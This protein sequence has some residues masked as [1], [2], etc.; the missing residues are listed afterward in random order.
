MARPRNPETD[1][2]IRL[3]GTKMSV[4]AVAA[5]LGLSE[6]VVTNAYYKHYDEVVALQKQVDRHEKAA[7]IKA[8]M[9]A[10][11]AKKGGKKPKAV[12]EAPES[13]P[14]S[15]ENGN[16]RPEGANDAMIAVSAAGDAGAV[17][18]RARVM[19]EKSLAVPL[20]DGAA[21]LIHA[22]PDTAAAAEPAEALIPELEV[23]DEPVYCI[24]D[25]MAGDVYVRVMRRQWRDFGK[26][27]RFRGG[28][29]PA[30]YPFDLSSSCQD[31]VFRIS[32][33]PLRLYALWEDGIN[34]ET[35]PVV[36]L[37]SLIDY[38]YELE[39][40]FRVER[41]SEP[42]P[43]S[44]Q[45]WIDQAMKRGASE[46][47]ERIKTTARELFGNA[48]AAAFPKRMKVAGYVGSGGRTYM[49]RDHGVQIM[50]LATRTDFTTAEIRELSDDLI[51][52][53]SIL[54]GEV[55]GA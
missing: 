18:E 20:P 30:V 38:E 21:D 48:K 5:Q 35:R 4:R 19:F 12:N 23:H 26:Y 54:D 13:T 39:Q 47:G 16:E 53:L 22:E 40:V 9:D 29:M 45:T 44:A 2:I 49:L 43:D 32:K 55:I 24:T 3:L 1:E 41:K 46:L 25:F 37:E 33:N 28:E 14:K 31:A 7:E 17:M 11:K 52:L 27:F 51:E 10:G 42:T 50:G 36:P 6:D 8:Q 15:A 34:Q